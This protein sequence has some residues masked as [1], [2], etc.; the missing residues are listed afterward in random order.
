MLIL[1]LL[2]GHNPILGE[3]VRDELESMRAH[4]TAEWLKQ[5][6]LSRQK[7]YFAWIVK[8]SPLARSYFL[9]F[10]KENIRIYILALMSQ[11][12]LYK[13]IALFGDGGDFFISAYI[14]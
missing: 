10:L 4:I 7:K 9:S 12:N 13:I 3:P 14:P 1:N 5:R 8:Y 2:Y 6:S 11:R